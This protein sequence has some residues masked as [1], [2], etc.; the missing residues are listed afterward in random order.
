MR[1]ENTEDWFSKGLGFKL[2]FS[3]SESQVVGLSGMAALALA[4]KLGV[5]YNFSLLLVF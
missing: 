4:S 5:A 3:C 2:S 1:Y